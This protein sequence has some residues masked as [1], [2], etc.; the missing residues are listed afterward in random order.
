MRMYIQIKMIYSMAG[1][2]NNYKPKVT[3]LVKLQMFLEKI[4]N[5]EKENGKRDIGEIF[6]II[7]I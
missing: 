7:F 2:C 4:E 1:Y 3:N 6:I 5:K